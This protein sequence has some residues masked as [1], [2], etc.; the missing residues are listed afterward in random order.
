MTTAQKLI[1]GIVEGD[2]GDF[3]KV[4]RG[5]LMKIAS[6]FKLTADIPFGSGRVDTGGTAYLKTSDER[7][8]KSA[9]A[10]VTRTLAGYKSDASKVGITFEIIEPQFWKG[11]WDVAIYLRGYKNVAEPK[12]KGVIGPGGRKYGHED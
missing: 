10:E 1:E 9:Y 3:Q 11:E 2:Q 8:I 7:A 12:Y 4:I 5:V 6:K